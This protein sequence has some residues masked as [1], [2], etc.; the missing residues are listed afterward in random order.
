MRARAELALIV[1]TI[2]WG[3][4]FVMVKSALQNISPLLFIGARFSLAA[5]VL[6]LIYARAVRKSGIRG[7]LLAGGL[8]FGAY[9]LQTVEIRFPH[10]TFGADGT[11]GEFARLS[12]K[13]PVDGSPG[14]RDFERR[15]HFADAA[16]R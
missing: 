13:T 3:T 11:F 16:G 8:L 4:T 12:R 6:W 14:D 5:V 1:V 2:M 10:I 15:H 9:A 7:G